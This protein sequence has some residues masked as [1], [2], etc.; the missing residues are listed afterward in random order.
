M[1][2]QSSRFPRAF[3]LLMAGSLLLLSLLMTRAAFTQGLTLSGQVKGT[4]GDA[5]QF[6][7]VSLEGPGQYVAITD[8]EGCF[9]IRNVIPGKY[10]VRVRQGDRV[11]LFTCNVDSARINLV[12][13]W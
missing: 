5:K 6:A 10:T 4:S 8:A 9:T 12:V 3:C 13:N 1:F 2:C 7:G 11:A